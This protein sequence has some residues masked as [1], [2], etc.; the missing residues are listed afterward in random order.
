MQVLTCVN[1]WQK[2]GIFLLISIV[3]RIRHLG[4]GTIN[5]VMMMR[6]CH[7]NDVMI[8]A[9]LHWLLLAMWHAN[10]LINSRVMWS[11]NR[12]INIY[13]KNTRHIFMNEMEHFESSDRFELWASDIQG[14]I[15][16]CT[17]SLHLMSPFGK[18]RYHRLIKH[19][20]D[21][22]G[23]LPDIAANARPLRAWF[24]HT[25]VYRFTRAK[26][27]AVTRQIRHAFACVSCYCATF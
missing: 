18:Y 8:A 15:H 24:C 21:T 12:R 6:R 9:T 10:H 26:T 22:R 23:T 2:S 19:I 16:A 17:A 20:S 27:F 4:E 14:G 1:W 25:S 5:D 11:A 7:D 3:L 13:R